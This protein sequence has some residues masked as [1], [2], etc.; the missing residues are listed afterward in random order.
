MKELKQTDD[1]PIINTHYPTKRRTHKYW[2]S[3]MTKSQ[4]KQKKMHNENI[5]SSYH[6][7][8]DYV[9]KNHFKQV[10]I[11]FNLDHKTGNDGVTG[12]HSFITSSFYWRLD[13]NL[14]R[15]YEITYAFN[16]CPYEAE[17]RELMRAYPL[18]RVTTLKEMTPDYDAFFKAV[19]DIQV[20]EYNYGVDL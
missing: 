13:C 18:D 9:R 11:F 1:K 16:H 2:T 15:D 10:E 12:M 4:F 14:L 6:N 19:I 17:V 8:I 3:A 5:E 7:V 20:A